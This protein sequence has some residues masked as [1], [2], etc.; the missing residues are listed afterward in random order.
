MD[1]CDSDSKNIGYTWKYCNKNGSP[2]RRYSNNY[3]IPIQQ[4]GE[5]AISSSEGLNEEFM[6]SNSDATNLFTTNLYN[7]IALLNKMN[8]NVQ[9]IEDKV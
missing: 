1:R 2:D 5:I 8:W 3:Q 6:I 7:F 4:Y 9:M